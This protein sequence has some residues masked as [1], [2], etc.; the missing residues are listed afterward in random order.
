MAES[1]VVLDPANEIN[2]M[3]TR[4]F[5]GALGLRVL[6]AT[7]DEVLAELDIRP[8]HLQPHGIVHGGVH[9]SIIETLAS[10][11]SAV[12]AYPSGRTV[13][14]LENHT[15]FIH[16]VREGTLRASA[17]P[18]TRGRRTQVWEATI[19]DAAQ[20]IVATGRVRMLVLEPDAVVAG[21]ELGT[22][23]G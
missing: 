13:V 23:I 17:T 16:A 6:K 10:I 20:R 14:G 3:H 1:D 22:T 7:R 21:A 15:S 5:A 11:G 2:A 9:A 8:D 18:L 19:R 4:T 12:D